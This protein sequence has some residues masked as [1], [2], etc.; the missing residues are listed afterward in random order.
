MIHLAVTT[1]G[2]LEETPNPDFESLF[3]KLTTWLM[4]LDCDLIVTDER[5]VISITKEQGYM[6]DITVV[7]SG[8]IKDLLPFADLVRNYITECEQWEDPQ[9]G[10]EATIVMRAIAKTCGYDFLVDLSWE[11]AETTFLSHYA[12]GPI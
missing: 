7:I 12:P 4:S 1:D 6:S 9:P 2:V 3:D 11:Y 5:I 10:N 8:G